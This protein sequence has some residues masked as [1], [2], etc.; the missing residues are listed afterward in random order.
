MTTSSMQV[1]VCTY[2]KFCKQ[3]KF[4]FRK[5]VH[6]IKLREMIQSYFAEFNGLLF[7]D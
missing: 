6:R 3:V 7:K 4:E 2:R 1:L 5:L